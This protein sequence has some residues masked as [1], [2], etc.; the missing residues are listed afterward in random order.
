MDR[1]TGLR[2]GLPGRGPEEGLACQRAVAFLFI[3]NKLFF[4]EDRM[5]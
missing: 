3:G 2:D 5:G 1:Y 4:I